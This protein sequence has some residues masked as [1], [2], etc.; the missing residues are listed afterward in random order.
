M[1]R[2]NYQS[3]SARGVI[4]LLPKDEASLLDLKNWRPIT[5]LNVDYKI[6]AKAIATRMESTLPFL[7]H[8]DQTG[9]IKGRYIGE[10]IR[11]ICDLLEQTKTDKSSEILLSIDFC[12]AFDSMEW[13]IMHKA[14]ETYNFGE[15]LRTWIRIFYKNIESTV[16][17]NGYASK[18]IRP[19]RGVRQGCPLSPFLFVLTA[20]LL[21]NKIHQSDT[22]K[23]ASLCGNE[24]KISQFADD[25]NLICADIPSVENAL[26]ILV[27]FGKISGLTLNKE[28]TKAM[29]LG[30]S[31]NNKDKPLGFK[32]VSCPTRFLGVHLSHDKKG[33]DYQNFDFKIGKLQTNLDMSRMR[34]LT[35]F[36]RTLIVKSLGISQVIHSAS[37]V[38][39]PN[40]VISTAKKR[41][42]SFLWK[43]KRD[44]IKRVGLYQNYDKGGLRM[45]DLECMIKALRT[46]WIP[47]LLNEGHQS[48]KT[49]PDHFFKRYGGLELILSCNYNVKF[50]ENLP[51]FYK[52]ILLYFSELKTLYNHDNMCETI[53]Y[54]FFR[55]L[56]FHKE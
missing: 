52:D 26:Q 24:I 6:A 34:D 8:T 18:W 48:W 30:R 37:N 56:F 27:D 15:S 45:P 33:N 36:G 11:L 54:L 1:K 17:N 28:K 23:G 40:Y 21:S 29:W 22:V 53:L 47:R 2:V 20:K 16:L 19:S 32:W 13:P 50:F 38:D 12:K 25:T 41:L 44:K 4:T 51:N 43:N 31:A 49:V 39:A 42:F 14:L 46:A 10:N 5:L 35:L 7:I 55:K 9:L 3:R